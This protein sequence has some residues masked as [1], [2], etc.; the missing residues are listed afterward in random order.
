[1]IARL[2]A[3]RPAQLT[4]PLSQISVVQVLRAVF[5]RGLSG[6]L[7]FTRDDESI[8]LRFIS[9]HV[10]SG[11]SEAVPGRLGEVL[12][13]SGVLDR[14]QLDPALARAAGQGRR[15]GPALVEQDLATRQQVEE[16]LRL[17]VCSV[18][19]DAL[20]WGRGSFRFEPND[21]S[22]PPLEEVSLGISTAQ[23][24]LQ[25]VNSLDSLSVRGLLGD[26]NRL[27]SAVKDPP[28]RLEAMT[29]SPGDAFVLSRADGD[30]TAR[31]L[32]EITPLPGETVERSLLALLSLGVVEYRSQ[33]PR[34]LSPRPGASQ[35]AARPQGTTGE[36]IP[37]RPADEK[38]RRFQEIDSIFVGLSHKS[39]HDVLGVGTSASADEIRKA[40]QRLATRFH[41][42]AV[43]DAPPEE[44]AKAKAIF[45]RVS[46]A[47]CALRSAL[48]RMSQAPRPPAAKP[49]QGPAPVLPAGPIATLKPQPE[50][51]P[52]VDESLRL[53]EEAL[54]ERPWEALGILERLV[55]R[56]TGTIRCRAR[57]LRARAMLKNP[58][59]LRAA[60]VELREI[61][62]ESP[63][64]ADAWLALGSFYK[65]RGLGARAA[66]MFRKALE[67]GPGNPRAT[68]E[69]LA[70]AG[71]EGASPR[72]SQLRVAGV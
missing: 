15:L 62:A 49:P 23:L 65:D 57:L 56:T 36:A 32:L 9:G 18:L 13:R 72:P 46:E 61:V 21:G 48:P 67:L 5:V 25:A 7:V 12:V 3:P 31:E 59:S 70:F 35:T 47:Y 14:A 10:V 43:G 66:S 51:E 60:E 38:P 17:Q 50:T 54:A 71:S 11:S 16:A 39:H 37:R 28:V 4:G 6:S 69:L 41:P 53:A 29:L 1:M 8:S 33:Q 24:I 45:M 55:L 58:A 2:L 30:L 40:Y 44:A 68:A 34:R 63:S 26:P 42:D 52:P 27:V 19:S 20:S 22:V 64:C